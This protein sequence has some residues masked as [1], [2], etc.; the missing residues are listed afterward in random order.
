ML[1]ALRPMLLT[2]E[3][4]LTLQPRV[5]YVAKLTLIPVS[6]RLADAPESFMALVV[7]FQGQVRPQS[8]MN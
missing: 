6:K 1:Y 5:C 8:H 3:F 2:A 4:P 7:E